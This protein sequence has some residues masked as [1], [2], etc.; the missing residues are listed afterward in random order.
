M[1][2]RN[3]LVGAVAGLTALSVVAAHSPASAADSTGEAAAQGCI[4][5]AVALPLG[6]SAVG[7]LLAPFTFGAS[8]VLVPS[9]KTL[10]AAA[11]A[12]C[13]TGGTEQAIAHE[14]DKDDQPREGE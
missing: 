10:A 5:G 8:L 7:I 6:M 13:V 2:V 11:V 4:A 9:G 1:Q 3:A 14:L 12:G